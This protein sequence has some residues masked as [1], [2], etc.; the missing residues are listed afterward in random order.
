MRKK[1]ATVLIVDDDADVLFAARVWLKRF[2]TKVLLSESAQKIKGIVQENEPDVVLLDMNYRKGFEDGREGLYWLEYLQEV[3]PETVV[4]LMTGFGDVAL[5]V[6]SLKK[7]AFDFVLK[8][9]DNDKLYATVNAAVDL[10]RKNKKVI[11]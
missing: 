2:F 1:E 7:G 8:P 4:V 3:Q 10:A 6:E 11:Q 5:A 9:W